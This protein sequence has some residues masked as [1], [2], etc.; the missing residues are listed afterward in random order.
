MQERVCDRLGTQTTATD[1]AK[2]NSEVTVPPPRGGIA[3][4]GG[5]GRLQGGGGGGRG[6]PGIDRIA[7][8]HPGRD[9]PNPLR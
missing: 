1:I 8:V 3:K 6:P 5:G 2:Q 4:V 7:G 9:P